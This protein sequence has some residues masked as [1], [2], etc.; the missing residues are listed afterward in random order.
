[1]CLCRFVFVSLCVCVT[2]CL[3]RFV[4]VSLCVC[5]A[6]CLCR[7]VFVSLRVCVALCLCHFV[8][9]SLCVCVALCLCRFVFVSLCV[10]VALCLCRFVLVALCP[11]SDGRLFCLPS[12]SFMLRS[13]S[14]I[15]VL[16]S[17]Y[18]SCELFDRLSGRYSMLNFCRL[19]GTSAARVL[20][21]SGFLI[22]FGRVL[23][24]L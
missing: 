1:M 8:F 5:V 17:T 3:C 13:T 9:V 20:S 23:G 21:F 16:A 11:W 18:I 6:V 15:L 19:Q 10:C 24:Q 12:V 22:E 7:V 14:F 2:L 4:F